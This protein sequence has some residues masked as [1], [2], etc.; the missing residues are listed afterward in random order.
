M[1][2]EHFRGSFYRLAEELS[3]IEIPSG[4][5]AFAQ[6]GDTVVVAVRSHRQIQL[7]NAQSQE[8]LFDAPN[9]AISVQCYKQTTSQSGA[10]QLSPL[11][12]SSLGKTAHVELFIEE[13]MQERQ[14]TVKCR[15][16]RTTGGVTSDEFLDTEMLMSGAFRCTTP[17]F[18]FFTL[19]TVLDSSSDAQLQFYEMIPTYLILAMLLLRIV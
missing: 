15:R 11:T 16:L 4:A 6:D 10:E 18:S 9:S 12:T 1:L 3:S 7:L 19:E 17:G 5:S 2:V 8:L 13:T 14:K